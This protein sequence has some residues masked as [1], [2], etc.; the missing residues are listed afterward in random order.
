MHLPL[1]AEKQDQAGTPFT[2]AVNGL[3]ALDQALKEL[4]EQGGWQARHARYHKLAE[5]C[6][7]R[8]QR[9]VWRPC[10]T[11]LSSPVFCILTGS[12]RHRATQTFM[13]A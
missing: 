9:M 1:W 11:R 6:R 3:L 12:R 7:K 5:A 2:P 13:M 8:L 4:A 10:W